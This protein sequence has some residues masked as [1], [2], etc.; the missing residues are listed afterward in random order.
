MASPR[1]TWVLTGS[2]ENFRATRERGFKLIGAKEGRRRMAERI[3]PGDE[4]VFYVTG[5][6]AFGGIV[7]VTS[8][9]FEDREKVWPGKPGKVDPYPWR[10][11]TEP[12]QVLDE[13]QFVPAVDLVG[14]A[15]PHREVARGSL[16]P[17]VPGPAS[18]GVRVGRAEAGRA[19]RRRRAQLRLGDRVTHTEPGERVRT[20][21]L[22]TDNLLKKGRTDAARE[23]LAQAREA[24]AAP[25]VDPQVRELVERRLTALDQLTGS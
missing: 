14:R 17:G 18:H 15:R 13:D 5:V 1:K 9:M 19:D 12:V 24:A 8:E 4:I 16:A 23:A 22:R 20:L 6:Q 21:L 2:V 3:E 10:F 7:R 11:E 25:S